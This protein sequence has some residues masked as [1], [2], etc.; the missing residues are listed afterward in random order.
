MKIAVI[1]ALLIS[2]GA[3]AEVKE[4]TAKRKLGTKFNFEDMMV[5]GRYQYP[6]EAV[7][8][9]EDEKGLND[10]LGVRKH[11][12]DRLQQSATRH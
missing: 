2:F 9:V 3:H 6:D 10:L 12:K 4:P 1:F 8:S 11:F 7:T 5:K